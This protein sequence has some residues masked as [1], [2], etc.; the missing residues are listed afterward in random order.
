MF[1][2]ASKRDTKSKVSLFIQKWDF[3]YC[4]GI[5]LIMKYFIF[6]EFLFQFHHPLPNDIKLYKVKEHC[7]EVGMHAIILLNIFISKYVLTFSGGKTENNFH[8]FSNTRMLI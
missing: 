2:N 7:V 6:L 5:L 1:L 4:N 3:F 8:Y